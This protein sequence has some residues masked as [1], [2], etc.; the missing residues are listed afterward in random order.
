[1][2]A[3]TIDNLSYRRRLPGWRI[4]IDR[5]GS[6]SRT[7]GI[8]WCRTKQCLISSAVPVGPTA[9]QEIGLGPDVCHPSRS[10]AARPRIKALDIFADNNRCWLA[11]RDA[12]E[13]SG[14]AEGSNEVME[15]PVDVMET[16]EGAVAE[17]VTRAGDQWRLRL[18]TTQSVP[19]TAEY[20]LELMLQLRELRSRGIL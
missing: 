18:G 4:R 7:A 3:F 2:K 5:P 9:C 15:Q 20:L 6:E 10:N 11:V 8:A 17:L 14:H 1:M 12:R 13:C 16:A 19:V